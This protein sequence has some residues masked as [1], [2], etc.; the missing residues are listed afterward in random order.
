DRRRDEQTDEVELHAGPR[1]DNCRQHRKREQPVR[2]AQD[3]ILVLGDKLVARPRQR[4]SVLR[5]NGLKL[6]IHDASDN[7]PRLG[8]AGFIRLAEPPWVSST[9]GESTVA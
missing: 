7:G 4:N 6:G 2:I 9:Y 3:A 8:P 1:A 5:V